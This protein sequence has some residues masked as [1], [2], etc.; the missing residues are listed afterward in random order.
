ME[1][2]VKSDE[3]PHVPL[4]IGPTAV[5][6][7]EV[8]ILVA[9]SIGGE[10]ISADSRQIYRRMNIGT[11]KPSPVELARVP[12]HL[13]DIADPENVFSAG[14]FARCAHCAIRGIIARG[15]IPL[16]VGGAGLYI[17]A[18]TQGLFDGKSS[19]PEVRRRLNREYSELGALALYRE[20]ESIDPEYAAIVHIN[21][22][23]KL[24]RALEIYRVT[25]LTVSQ[26]AETEQQGCVEGL[27]IGLNGPREWLYSRIDRRVEEMFQNS[28]LDEVK[29][30]KDNGCTREMNSMN[31]PGYREIFAYFD[32]EIDYDKMV[33][34]IKRNTRRYAKRQLTWFRRLGDSVRWFEADWEAEEI[35]GDIVKF[36]NTQKI[37]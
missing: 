26:L 33:E 37:C 23:K 34:L 18:M 21:D 32:N 19:N 20:L 29:A 14:E 12:H 31:S 25:G 11:A 24:L 8:G 35:A 13:I 5:G 2:A 6:K 17:Q 9:E 7:T 3:K 22:R 30:L 10:I 4:L 28:L 16:V 36:L 15:K 1:E 27:Y